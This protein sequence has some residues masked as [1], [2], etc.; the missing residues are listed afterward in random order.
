MATSPCTIHS[1]CIWRS[2]QGEVCAYNGNAGAGEHEL[3]EIAHNDMVGGC[4]I[5]HY[6]LEMGDSYGGEHP[7]GQALWSPHCLDMLLPHEEYEDEY[8][9]SP[10]S[11]SLPVRYI[12]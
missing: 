10:A 11:A 4:T 7:F 9:Q 1:V 5:R 8:R 3:T 12:L 2:L 6:N